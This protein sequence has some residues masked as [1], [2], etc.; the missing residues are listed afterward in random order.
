MSTYKVYNYS[1]GPIIGHPQLPLDNN[2]LKDGED[3]MI[4]KQEFFQ[5]FFSISQG[6]S[7]Y[8]KTRH[9]INILMDEG[10]IVIFQIDNEKSVTIEE[11][12]KKR[13]EKDHPSCIVIVD[14]RKDVQR[15]LIENNHA[16]TNPDVVKNILKNIFRRHMKSYSLYIDIWAASNPRNFWKTVAKYPKGIKEIKFIFPRKNLPR[17][18]DKVG[19][20][21]DYK[22]LSEDTNCAPIIYMKAP[23]GTLHLDEGNPRLNA[24]VEGSAEVGVGSQCIKPVGSRSYITCGENSSVTIN[25]ADSIVYQPQQMDAFETRLEKIAE[26]LNSLKK[27]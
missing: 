17:V 20:Y 11:N 22:T 25:I 15:I 19:P 9:Y 7:F 16:F 27:S 1:F 5:R 18:S 23:T 8:H 14:N 13:Q 2:L 10:N 12:F 24:L 3:P 21:L 4:H 6:K 26:K